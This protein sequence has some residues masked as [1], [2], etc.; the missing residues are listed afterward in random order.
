MYKK[1]EQAKAKKNLIITSI[2]IYGIILIVFFSYKHNKIN[3]VTVLKY[4]R[5]DNYIL[6]RPEIGISKNDDKNQYAGQYTPWTVKTNGG[7]KVAYLTFDDGPSL[8]T[9]KILNILNKNNIK[10][11]FFLI[12]KNAEKHPDLVKDEFYC[13]EVIGN[14]TYSH[15]LNYKEGTESFINDLNKCDEVLKSILGKS[16]NSKLI[17]FPGGSFGPKL[18]PFR[19]S[20]TSAG[21]RFIDWNDA[22]GDANGYNLPVKTLLSNLKKYT[23][24]N[25]VVILMH[26]AGAKTTTAEAL[27]QIIEYLKS[28]GY[29]F[30]TLE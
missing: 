14:H 22:I 8:N 23:T 30:D 17:R 29:S 3:D 11:T 20:V 1:D 21:Y 10:A 13:G 15:Q 16:Y 27:P 19:A 5:T 18:E 9:K 4:G 12:G 24:Q 7:K 28:K 25:T 2:L 6:N 26:D